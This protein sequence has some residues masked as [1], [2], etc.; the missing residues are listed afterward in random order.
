MKSK[1]FLKIIVFG[2]LILI[3]TPTIASDGEQGIENILQQVKSAIVA[4][5]QE[6]TGEPRLT[7]EKVIIDL[8]VSTSKNAEGE[9]SLKIPVV[10]I[11]VGGSAAFE[12]KNTSRLKMEFVP[13]TDTYVSK[14][15]D[16]G[17]AKAIKSLK[18][19]IQATINKPPPLALNTFTY[20]TSFVI[21]KKGGSDLQ[22]WVIDAS[23]L[24]V[25]NT[26]VNMVKIQ[27]SVVS[28]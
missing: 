7:I 15:G 6:K 14:S 17:L 4:A 8:A 2:A 26:A 18:R 20:E 9:I 5:Q 21:V 22:L 1:I 3:A 25:Q 19:A 16:L 28:D 10:D 27:M 23:P 12:K 11:G 24:Q 13:G